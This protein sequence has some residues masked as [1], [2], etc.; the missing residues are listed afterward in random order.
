VKRE[1]TPVD[2]VVRSSIQDGLGH[3]VRS[4]CVAKEL[5]GAVPVRVIRIGDGS[6]AHLVAEAGLPSID[7]P[8]DEDAAAAVVSDGA[9]LCVFDTLRFDASSFARIADDATTVSLSPEFSCLASTDHLVHR[10]EQEDPRWNKA[11]GFPRIHKGLRYTILPG[12]LKRIPECT[13]REHASEERLAVAISMGGSD[14]SNRTLELLELLNEAPC[15]LVVFIALGD[16]YTHSYE[17]LLRH[18]ESNRQEV[19]LVKSNESMWRVLRTASLLLC[20]GGL[21]TYEAVFVGIPSINVL[22][23]NEWSYLFE[24]LTESGA[25]IT[26]PPSKGAYELTIAR[27]V[28][29]YQNRSSLFAMHAATKGRV[30]RGGAKRVASLLCRLNSAKKSRA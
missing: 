4:L 15:S 11:H 17:K 1:V 23:R 22:Q 12:W 7:C 6:G 18:A 24:E 10:T 14:A 21:T 13:Y 28:E 26:V 2:F 29:L 5:V 9:R 20:A 8:N 30:P 3:L 19:I 16:A 27:V 25:C